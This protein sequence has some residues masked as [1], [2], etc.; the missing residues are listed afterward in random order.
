MNFYNGRL[1]GYTYG[2]NN[3]FNNVRSEMEI[4]AINEV[5]PDSEKILTIS[6]TE[7][8]T[9]PVSEAAKIGNGY[10]KITY[11]DETNDTCTNGQVEEFSHVADED[12]YSVPFW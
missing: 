9:E 7:I 2:Y 6:T 12:T 5:I 10:A 1:R 3:T 11:I 8:S 4:T